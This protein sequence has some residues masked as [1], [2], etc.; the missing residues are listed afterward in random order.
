MSDLP[1]ADRVKH[2]L[3]YNPGS[4]AFIW[5]NPQSN[6]AKVGEIAGSIFGNGYRYIGIDGKSY[7]CSRL[8]WLVTHGEWPA[9]KIDHADGN[10]TNDRISNLRPCSHAENMQN[11][12]K[13]KTRAVIASRHVGVYWNQRAGRWSAD[14][15]TNRQRLRL[16][17]FE[18]EDDAAAA[19]AAAK[20]RVH[21]FQPTLRPESEAA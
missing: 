2:L 17:L 19:Y 21:R 8:A 10:P 13:G 9:D 3:E 1:T 16:G 14:I 15:M 4:G 7:K 5:V 12:R 18:C 6:R 11:V 20:A